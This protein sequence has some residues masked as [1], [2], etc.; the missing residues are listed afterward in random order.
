MYHSDCSKASMM[1][2]VKLVTEYP[3]EDGLPGVLL[4]IDPANK[5]NTSFGSTWHDFSLGTVYKC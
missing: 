4:L 1:P 2:I 3:F 5:R